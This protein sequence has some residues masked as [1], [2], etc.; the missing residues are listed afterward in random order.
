MKQYLEIGKV[1]NTHG[2]KGEIKLSMWCDDIDYLKQLKTV[3]LDDEGK[4][5]LTLIN[6][7]SQK[8]IAILKFAEITSVEQ[9]Q[10]LKNKDFIA[11]EMTQPLMTALIILQTLSAAKLLMLTQTRIT[12]KSLM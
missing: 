5:P 8:N 12:E 6:A 1:N 11:T 4:I 2:L 9:A 10:E 3:Y 7:R